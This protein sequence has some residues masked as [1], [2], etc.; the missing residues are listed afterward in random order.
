M[1]KPP[2]FSNTRSKP[3]AAASTDTLYVGGFGSYHFGGGNFAI[4][5]GSIRFFSW[6]IDDKVFSN[7][8]N[9]ADGNL[10]DSAGY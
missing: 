6:D 2:K 9:R 7:F 3:S 1:E 4:A 10:P 5:D 8:G